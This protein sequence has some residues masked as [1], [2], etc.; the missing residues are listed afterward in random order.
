MSSTPPPTMPLTPSNPIISLAS[1]KTF[2]L[3]PLSGYKSPLFGS[4]ERDV[5]VGFPHGAII[6]THRDDFADYVAAFD[7]AS[8]A[9]KAAA[10]AAAK[11]TAA[12]A[13]IFA[14]IKNEDNRK[15]AT[16]LG[17]LLSYKQ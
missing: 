11:A 8:A 15:Y 5:H 3:S 14:L 10:E 13:A 7:A 6:F 9:A 17:Q 4:P 12:A 2:D 1:S 16:T